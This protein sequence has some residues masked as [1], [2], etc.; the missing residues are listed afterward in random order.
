MLWSQALRRR[1][2]DY[3]YAS[4]EG[5]DAA[6]VEAALAAIVVDVLDETVFQ[7]AFDEPY[8]ED[9]RTHPLGRVVLG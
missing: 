7:A 1:I 6:H 2:L 4:M 5:P 9:R 8:C 3:W